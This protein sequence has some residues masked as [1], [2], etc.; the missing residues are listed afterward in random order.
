MT[1]EQ[2][3]ARDFSR[4]LELG[5]RVET[6]KINEDSYVMTF[7]APSYFVGLKYTDIVMAKR[8]NLLL[9]VAMREETATNVLGMKS[10]VKTTIDITQPD[11]VVQEHDV[12]TCYGRVDDFRS[13]MKKVSQNS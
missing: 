3:A 9:I 1:P 8:F 13:M 11:E 5:S 10:T 4:E 12:F 7:E 2:R 6:L